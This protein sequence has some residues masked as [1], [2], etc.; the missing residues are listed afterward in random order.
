MV[1]IGQNRKEILMALDL[2][3]TWHGTYAEVNGEARPASYSRSLESTYQENKFTIRI[4]GQVEHEGT[5]S[6]NESTNPTQI[7]FVYIKSSHFQLNTPRTGILQVVG[8]TYKNCMGAIG[9]PV[10]DEFNTKANSNT[11]LTILDKRGA[12]EGPGEGAIQ[13]ETGIRI[14]AW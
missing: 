3:G 14:L 9:G 11:V 13:P 8:D 5:Y 6:L 12:A 1:E 10:P 7:T 4:R 2:T